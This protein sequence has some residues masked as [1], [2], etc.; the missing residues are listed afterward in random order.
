MRFMFLLAVIGLF[1][2]QAAEPG[3]DIDEEI[4]SFMVLIK[5][6][7]F[8]L[9]DLSGLERENQRPSH[10]VEVADFFLGNM[11]VANQEFVLFLN[12]IQPAIDS[13]TG[14][15]TYHR[16]GIYNLALCQDCKDWRPGISYRNGRF[17]VHAGMQHFPVAMVTWFGA[18]E[19]CNWKS[20]NEGLEE[21][22]L[23]DS[24]EIVLNRNA[25]GY[26]LPT[27]AEWEY[28]AKSGGRNFKYAWGNGSIPHG[29]VRDEFFA[30]L[31]E[32]TTNIWKGYN[33]GYANSAPVNLFKQGELGLY[34]MTGN[35]QEWCWDWYGKYGRNKQSN[36]LGPEAGKYKVLRGG[37][38]GVYR[39]LAGVTSRN[40]Q[41][42]ASYGPGYGFRIARSAFKTL[43]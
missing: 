33:D 24:S 19:Y 4:D 14:S 17:V 15:L 6:G 12:S 9:G 39:Q 35:V 31:Y 29:N 32:D 5:G 30:R 1:G 8:T 43:E 7:C 22:Y 27:E 37:S 42:P 41:N 18:I 23:V 13:V 10:L 28:A 21:V 20:R 2:C 26:R 3:Y 11:E 36:P 38:M 16:Y 25:N 40:A 34:N